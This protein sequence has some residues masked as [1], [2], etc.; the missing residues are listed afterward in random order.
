LRLY[1]E[2]GAETR[3]FQRGFQGFGDFLSKH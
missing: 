1:R 2:R 3:A